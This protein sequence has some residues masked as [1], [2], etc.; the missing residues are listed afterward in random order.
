[1]LPARARRH[2]GQVGEPLD[3]LCERDA[4]NNEVIEDRDRRRHGAASAGSKSS[5]TRALLGSKKK[6]CQMPEPACLRNAY[7]T[8]AA[9]SCAILSLRPRAEKAMWAITPG[10]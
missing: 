3:R 1:M 8:P 6:I 10:L 7:L 4:R 9:S 5:S 2:A